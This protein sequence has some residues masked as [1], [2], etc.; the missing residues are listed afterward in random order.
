M[1]GASV[2][3]SP[4]TAMPTARLDGG[5]LAITSVIAIGI[6]AP[7]VKPCSMRNTIMLSRFQAQ[8]HKVENT[9]NAEVVPIM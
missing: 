2:A 6:R 7:P 5:S 4:N 1:V 9:R 3:V 8:P